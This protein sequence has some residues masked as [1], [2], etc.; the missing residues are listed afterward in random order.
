MSNLITKRLRKFFVKKNYRF[1]KY[2]MY[3]SSGMSRGVSKTDAPYP[4]PP[5]SVVGDLVFIMWPPLVFSK[6]SFPDLYRKEVAGNKTISLVIYHI[7]QN[8]III[9]PA[10]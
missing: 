9:L 10:N 3:C 7:T 6:T 2:L 5:S 4:T 8:Y 1:S